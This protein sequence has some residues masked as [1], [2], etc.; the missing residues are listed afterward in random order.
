MNTHLTDDPL[1][2]GLRTWAIEEQADSK[3]MPER[4]LLLARLARK[5][6]LEARTRALDL[7]LL[8][9]AAT[10]LG[11]IILISGHPLSFHLPWRHVLVTLPLLTA[12][13][14]VSFGLTHSFE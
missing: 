5:E 2:N 10:A 8:G 3:A 9:A 6:K 11:I 4:M 7:W 13:G 12:L 1:A 14:I